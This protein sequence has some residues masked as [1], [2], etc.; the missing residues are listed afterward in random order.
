MAKINSKN[1]GKIGELELVNKL[2]EFGFDCRRS[3]Q[4]KGDTTNDD[5]ADLVG[6][7]DLH[8]ECKRVEKLN[9]EEALQQAERDNHNPSKIPLVMWRRNREEWKATVRLNNFIKL[10]KGWKE[11]NERNK[12]VK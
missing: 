1:K 6:I 12:N 11:N 7:D 5:D 3:Q 2:K 4:F 10:F 9:V 8:I